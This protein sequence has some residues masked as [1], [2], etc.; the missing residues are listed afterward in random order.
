[1]LEKRNGKW[2]RRSVLY[3]SRDCPVARCGARNTSLLPRMA[4]GSGNVLGSL[5]SW[6]RSLL[7]EAWIMYH[8]TVKSWKVESREARD[9][10]SD[11]TGFLA[12]DG[13]RRDV[14]STTSTLV[15]NCEPPCADPIM[16]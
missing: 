3:R 16:E 7:N 4:P 1:M 15:I 10:L 11:I 12:C 13:G 9:R 5:Y 6:R 2:R 14:G 8:I